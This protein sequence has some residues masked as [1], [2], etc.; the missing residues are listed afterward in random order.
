VQFCPAA[1]PSACL[2]S[3]RTDIGIETSGGH[4]AEQGLRY[5]WSCQNCSFTFRSPSWNA[6]GEGVP[7]TA[8]ILLNQQAGPS[9][10][11]SAGL[12]MVTRRGVTGGAWRA[13]DD[14]RI[15]ACT[16][17]SGSVLIFKVRETTNTSTYRGRLENFRS[18]E[19]SNGAVWNF[20][21]LGCE[22]QSTRQ[23][24]D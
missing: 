8:P 3:Q 17:A 24:R 22:N 1:S 23:W 7:L 2:Q 5:C 15:R 10:E 18:R 14:Q 4:S 11:I 19:P 9:Y 6:G 13:S 20:F 21:P 16:R 12:V